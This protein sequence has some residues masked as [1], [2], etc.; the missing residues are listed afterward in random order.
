MTSFKCKLKEM[1][2]MWGNTGTAYDQTIAIMLVINAAQS[3][4]VQLTDPQWHYTNYL[5]NKLVSFDMFVTM[6]PCKP[7]VSDSYRLVATV[8]V[9][10][11]KVRYVMAMQGIHTSY[12][13][14]SFNKSPSIYDAKPAPLSNC[15]E[16]AGSTELMLE[17]KNQIIIR[18]FP[19]FCG[20]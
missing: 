10:W 19:S 3:V 14:Y 5:Y 12:I 1:Y 18:C 9:L 15:T 8:C 20:Q 16:H 17:Q 7:H 13:F 6:Q 11:V 4:H 2:D